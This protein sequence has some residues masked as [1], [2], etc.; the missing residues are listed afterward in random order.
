MTKHSSYPKPLLPL[1]V[2]H[3][4]STESCSR[5]NFS[6]TLSSLPFFFECFHVTFF[7]GETHR[8]HRRVQTGFKPPRLC[9]AGNNFH[10]LSLPLMCSRTEQA[11]WEGVSWHQQG[12]LGSVAVSNLEMAFATSQK[13]WLSLLVTGRCTLFSL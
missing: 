5:W 11:Q 6:A 13:F 8:Q 3:L 2:Q 10:Y 1:Q 12:G 4:H 7:T 9:C